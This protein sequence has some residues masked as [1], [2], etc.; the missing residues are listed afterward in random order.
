LTADCVSMTADGC[1]SAVGMSVGDDVA[2]MTG[3]CDRF[4]DDGT[5]GSGACYAY[6]NSASALPFVP[7][8]AVEAILIVPVTVPATTVLCGISL[9]PELHPPKAT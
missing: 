8:F 2:P 1:N 7:S 3:G 4:G 9:P 5:R 6:C